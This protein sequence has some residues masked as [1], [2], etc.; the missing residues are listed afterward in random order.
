[1]HMHIGVQ[2]GIIESVGIGIYIEY[3]VTY[4]VSINSQA[5]GNAFSYAACTLHNRAGTYVYTIAKYT[6]TYT[7]LSMINLE[8]CCYRC[9][10]K[11]G[12]VDYCR[13]A[14]Y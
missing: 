6:Y 1:M 12:S 7:R 14:L 11:L 5:W 3:V 13:L 4:T 8:L 10:R 9:I 2:V